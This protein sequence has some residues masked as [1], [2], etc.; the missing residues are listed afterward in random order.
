MLHNIYASKMNQLPNYVF[1]EVSSHKMNLRRLGEDI[2]DFS[3]GNPDGPTPAHIIDKLIEA[4]KK[5][6]NH[7]YSNSIGIYKLRLAITKWYKD[8]FGVQLDPDDEAV[9]TM[10]SKEGYVHLVHAITNP[11]D[12]AIVP[13]PTYPISAYAFMLAGVTARKVPIVFNDTY[14]LDEDDLLYRIQIAIKESVPKPKF[15]SVNFPHNPTTVTATEEFYRKLVQLAKKEQ[16]VIISDIAYADICYDGYETPSILSIPGA[17]DVSVEC[18]TLSKSYNM[19]GWRVGFVV[20][21][22]MMVKA[23]QKIKKMDR[24]WYVY[25]H[26]NSSHDSFK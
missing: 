22:P 2:I 4:S 12:V 9:I 1:A 18:F 10:G 19:A 26:T 6:K 24:L 8:R 5:G 20:G 25:T 7:G 11:G 21:N 13:E 16:F 3:M 23:L 17:K 15:V 14:E